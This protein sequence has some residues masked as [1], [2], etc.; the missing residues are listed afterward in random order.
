[1]KVALLVCLLMLWA[2]MQFAA[3]FTV[4]DAGARPD[5]DTDD[6][7]AIQKLID[8]LKGQSDVRIVFPAGEYELHAIGKRHHTL[9]F[10][11]ID[12]LVVDGT[13]AELVFHGIKAGLV[14]KSCHNVGVRGVAIDWDPPSFSVGTVTA[15]PDNKTF[16]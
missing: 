14:F 3:E 2:H 11:D 5:D 10:Q 7:P 4:T 12:D 16:V 8:G 9:L 1:M 13:G 6:A 15:A